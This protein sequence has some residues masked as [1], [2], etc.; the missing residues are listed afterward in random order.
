MNIKEK[1]AIVACSNG[2]A[3]KQKDKIEQLVETLMGIN[4]I[5]ILS[6]HIFAK[7]TVFS[8]IGEERAESLMQCYRDD[9]I[10]RIFDISGGDLAN[11][12]L[13][14][15]DYEVIKDSKKQ[16]WGYSDLTTV[17]NAIYT[18]TGKSSVLYQIRNLLNDSS[19]EQLKRFDTKELFDFEY[20]LL[21]GTEMRGVLVGGNIRCLLKLAGTEY[22]PDMSGKVLLLEAM[23]GNVPKMITALNQLKQ[24]KV[25]EKI[26]G[27]ILGTFSEME[28]EG[29]RPTIEELVKNI[30]G[31]DMP[32]AKTYEIGHGIN[33]KAIEIGKEIYLSG[34][35]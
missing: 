15:L 32:I 11:E 1:V 4:L 16:F 25:F 34:G 3:E 23:S 24:M 5:P 31:P 19:G 14:H 17:I 28:A 12:I 8:G 6:K 7:G 29:Y 27:I 30:V 10:Q 21:Q 26:N 20:E 22:W 35:K 2:L 33:S 9:E 13:P 18:K